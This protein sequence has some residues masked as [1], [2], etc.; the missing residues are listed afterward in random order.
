MFTTIQ[1]F[2]LVGIEAVPVSVE[3]DLLRRLPRTVIVGLPADAVKE[4]AERVRSAIVAA[5]FE[6]PRMRVVVNL[7]PADLRK[8]VASAF[9]LPIAVGILVASGQIPAAS[10][11][12][13]AFY[14]EL[15]LSGDVRPVRGTVA[16]AE[17]VRQHGQVLVTSSDAP[18]GEVLHMR[19][20]ADI[21]LPLAEAPDTDWSYAV[22][23]PSLMAPTESPPGAQEIREGLDAGRPVLIVTRLGFGAARAARW[24]SDRL[25]HLTRAA[26]WPSDRGLPRLT[27]DDARTIATITD[28]AG[29]PVFPIQIPFRA[30]H[31]TVSI[32]GM[33]GDRSL[34]PGECITS[35]ITLRWPC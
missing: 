30:P 15:S 32:A 35:C 9:D 21:R 19:S 12:G 17:A 24:A 27:E 14:G 28:A 8:T 2:T 22:A 13:L 1:S 16:A 6:Y 5:G 10:V 11:A 20:L 25:P 23:G 3:V 29:L 26:R 7:A 31:H 4:T 34:R 18:A 33:F